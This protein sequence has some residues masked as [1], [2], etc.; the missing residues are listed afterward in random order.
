MIINLPI[1]YENDEKLY[2]NYYYNYIFNVIITYTNINY[3]PF[4]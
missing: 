4:S 2:F 1:D 3:L